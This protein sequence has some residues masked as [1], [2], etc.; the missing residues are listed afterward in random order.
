MEIYL[1]SDSEYVKVG[2][3]KFPRRRLKQLQTSNARTLE[4]LKSI[5]V[6]NPESVEAT[7]HGL[8]RERGAHIRGEW[9][10]IPWLGEFL[11]E[12]PSMVKRAELKS[13][14]NQAKKSEDYSQEILYEDSLLHED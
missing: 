8:L 7:I 2:I 5:P 14:K 1:I 10:T 13:R 6:D 12:F 9:F 11:Q 4:L 3:S